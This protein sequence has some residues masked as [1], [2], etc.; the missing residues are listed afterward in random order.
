MNKPLI[1]FD[2]DGTLFHTEPVFTEAARMA[3]TDMGI[4]GL[5]NDD[6]LR[7]IGLPSSGCA[8]ALDSDIDMA[9]IG[10][11]LQLVG[12]Y[13][14]QLIPEIGAAYDG[15]VPLLEYLVDHGFEL[16]ICSNGGD[17]YIDLVLK[18]CA[19]R[20]HFSHIRGFEDGITKSE[21]VGS[22]LQECQPTY[23]IMVGD[24]E[25]DLIAARDNMIPFVGVTYGYGG[26]EIARA[27][28]LVDTPSAIGGVVLRFG[29]FCQIANDLEKDTGGKAPV[30]GINGI[31]ASG[32]TVFAQHLADYLRFRCWR[33]Q[34][35]HLDDYLNVSTVRSRGENP[36]QAYIDNAFNLRK[37]EFELLKP[38]EL[39]EAI[40]ISLKHLDLKTDTMSR[41]IEYWIDSRTIVI[42]EGVL[43]YREPI[44]EY[45]DYRVYLD[46][47]FEEMLSR[48]RKRD[49][50]RF[51]EEFMD[52]YKEKYI[53]IQE[54][55]LK[56][57]DPKEKSDMVIDNSDFDRP[58]V[59]GK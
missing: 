31:D 57:C 53:P 21:Q 56:T 6:L 5:D 43:L 44:N 49:V 18:S 29:L 50:P 58:E 30:V 10:E 24:R 37:L 17:T 15:V 47:S 13:E 32:K 23:A 7:M 12:R 8:D 9:K 16:A 19:V 39:H 28:F 35:I 26:D 36:I 33:V 45:F 55:Y 25:M 2:L 40:H 48:A 20:K 52:R 54:W 27:D 22:L 1:I 46:I 4:E 42:I 38:I 11:F 51:G 3:A 14:K 41:E 34:I 59:R